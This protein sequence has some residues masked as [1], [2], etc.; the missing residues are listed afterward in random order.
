M[1][2]IFQLFANTTGKVAV[3]MYLTMFHGPTHAKANLAYLWT[4]GLLQI[5]SVIVLIA[6]ILAQCS[7]LEKLWE[8]AIPGA[9]NGRI[10]NQNFAFFQGSKRL[11]N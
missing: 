1:A 3:M 2:Q 10:R 8:Q 9:C 4:L 6:F 11:T 7:P 5:A